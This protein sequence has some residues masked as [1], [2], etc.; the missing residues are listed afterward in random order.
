MSAQ[1]TEKHEFKAEIKQLLDIV[2]HS[3]YTEKEI[4][5]RELISNASDA[6]EKLRHLKITEKDVH[7]DELELEIN[8]KTDEEAGTLTIQDYG[9]GLTHEELVEN[10]G[11][12][13][14]SGSKQFLQALKEGGEKNAD[15]IGQ[16]GVGFY[17]AFMVATKVEVFTHSW[18]KDEPGHVWSSDGVGSYEIETSDDTQRGA[19][20]VIH[21]GDDYKDYAKADTVKEIIKRYSSFVQFPIKLNDEKVNTVDA[22]WLRS[23][24]EITDEEYTEFYKFQAN[25]F[26]EPHYRLHFS[27]DAPLDIKALIFTP[28]TNP[29]RIGF[30][31]ID[32]GVA[33]HCRKVLID[34]KPTELLP[35]WLRFLKGVIDSADLPLNISRE[36]MQD[37]GLTQKLSRVITK[38]YLKFLKEEAKKRPEQ[39]AEFFKNFGIYLKEGV[40][41]DFTYRDDLAKLLYFESSVT[42]KG[43]TTSLADYVSRMKDE[44]KSIY[45]ILGQNR[46]SIESGPYLEGFKARG[47]EVLF[48]YEPIDEYV[49]SNLG[50]FEEKELTSADQGD[51]KLDDAPKPEGET[52]SDDDAKSLCEW[53]KTAIGDRVKEVK[54]SERL[55]SSPVMALSPDAM[56]TQ[57]RRMMKQMGQDMP[58]PVEVLFE[59]NPRHELIKNLNTQ[60]SS[61]EDLAKLIAQQS[62]D[63]ALVAAGLME[64]PKDMVARMYQ[65]LEQAATK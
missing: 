29:E 14:H 60:R 56:S 30:P 18:K 31:R 28:K 37:N 58:M 5:V 20:I 33:L 27:A 52:L 23:K 16:F 44:Q 45:Y 48:L 35:E 47:I 49:M 50:T 13:A 26:D 3:L 12:I 10:L 2:I 53:L 36:T 22:L 59:I 4:F 63:N 46:E 43:K 38:R 39:Y 34:S 1:N 19:R 55:V 21:L 51:I 40:A 15:L 24:S 8:I 11:T 9:I 57:M 25:A 62:F 61:N 65:I 54:V 42:E 41:T 17:S 7:Q 6:L 32:P 64:D